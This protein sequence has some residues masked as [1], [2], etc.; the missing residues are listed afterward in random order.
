LVDSL[1]Q[2]IQRLP[3]GGMVI[4]GLLCNERRTA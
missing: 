1:Q 2:E 3:V 4:A